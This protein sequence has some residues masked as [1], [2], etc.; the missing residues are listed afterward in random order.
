MGFHGVR[1]VD[2][3]YSV[4]ELK[5]EW[6]GGFVPLDFLGTPAAL[7]LREICL[8]RG[9]NTNFSTFVCGGDDEFERG[10]IYPGVIGIA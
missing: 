8:S 5:V 1:H 2:V 4:C 6:E 7:Q 9:F 10:R 3:S